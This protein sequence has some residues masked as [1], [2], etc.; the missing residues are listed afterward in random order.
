L[1]KRLGTFNIKSDANLFEAS[2]VQR[3]AHPFFVL[4]QK[5]AA[6]PRADHL[7]P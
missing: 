5:K 1:D 3:V 7:A 6:A 2:L 4:E